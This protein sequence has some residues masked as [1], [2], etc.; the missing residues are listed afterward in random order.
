MKPRVI[1]FLYSIVLATVILLGAACEDEYDP[2]IL[3]PDDPGPF[4]AMLVA[5]QPRVVINSQHVLFAWKWTVVEGTLDHAEIRLHANGE[6]AFTTIPISTS[7][8]DTTYTFTSLEPSTAYTWYIYAEGNDT[9][10]TP[11]QDTASYE[12]LFST[13]E[14]LHIPGMP[15]SP[16][17]DSGA[18]AVGTNPEFSWEVFNPDGLSYQ[19]DIFLGTTTEPEL[20]VSGLA[21]L[22]F[23]YGTDTL[24][25]GTKY[26]WQVRVRHDADTIM[27]PLW[28]FTTD[29]P[30]EV[31]VFA[32]FEIDV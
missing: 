3:E 25:Y 19:Y 20:L 8:T 16:T 18:T 23:S 22:N 2:S 27:G 10:G 24:D 21:G 5:P 26:Y 6:A 15:Y 11:F 31:D 29:Y 30:S 13:A 32:L 9:E 1:H 4:H 17:P 28:H 14:V 12:W 7:M